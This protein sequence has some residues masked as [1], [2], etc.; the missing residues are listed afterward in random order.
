MYRKFYALYRY[1]VLQVYDWMCVSGNNNNNE[2]TICYGNALHKCY[3]SRR[4]NSRF[5]VDIVAS[6]HIF[7][8]ITLV[9]FVALNF[10]FFVV[11]PFCSHLYAWRVFFSL[12]SPCFFFSHHRFCTNQ[13][14]TWNQ[15]MTMALQPFDLAIPVKMCA[16]NTLPYRNIHKLKMKSN[17]ELRHTPIH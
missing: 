2:W 9:N 5:H 10:F 3:W 17:E 7:F 6:F 12:S 4:S 15:R 11:F 16:K 1:S 8:S 14:V 13:Q